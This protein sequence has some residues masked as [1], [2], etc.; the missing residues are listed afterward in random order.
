MSAKT[1]TDGH[2][3]AL[4]SPPLH[5]R[6]RGDADVAAINTSITQSTGPL[7]HIVTLP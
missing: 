6:I 2:G 5:C 7:R 4:R 3:V 1:K